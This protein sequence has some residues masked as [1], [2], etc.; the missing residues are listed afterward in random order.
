MYANIKAA[1]ERADE[2]L[3]DLEKEYEESLT[4]QQVSARTMQLCHDLLEKVRSAL[5]RTAR[6]YFEKHVAPSLSSEDREAAS[7][8]FPIASDEHSFNSIMGRWRWKAV[9]QQHVDFEGYLAS[10]QPYA[11]STNHWLLQLNTLVNEGKHVDLSPQER[12]ESRQVT[13][14]HPGGGGV[15]YGSGVR[16]GAGVR[17]LGVPVDPRTQRVIPN[18][19][20]TEKITVWVDFK[21]TKHGNSALGFSREALAKAKAIVEQMTVDFDLA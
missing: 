3:G 2:I 18:D 14:T 17:I 9:K 5:D 4:K 11:N 20:V 15:S 8:Y 16:F 1:F 12:V 21:F 10:Q 7:I 13:V 19:V 6:R